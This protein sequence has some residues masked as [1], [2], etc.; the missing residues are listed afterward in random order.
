M[1]LESPVKPVPA[2]ELD[3]PFEQHPTGTTQEVAPG[4][5]WVRMPLPFALDHINVWLVA[6]GAHWTLVDCGLATDTTRRLWEEIFARDLGGKPVGR[7]IVTHYHPDHI[8]LA[9][10][11]SARLKVV[12]W[13]TKGEFLTAHAACHSV[14][15]T[16]LPRVREFFARHGLAP[17]RLARC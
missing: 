6:D 3:Y 9:G 8:G 4:V 5:L 2:H 15:G 16:G 13:M 14:G 11:M 12:P 17:E 10:W 7:V 1:T